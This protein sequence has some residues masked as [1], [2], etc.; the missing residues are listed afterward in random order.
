MDATT[1]SGGD[2]HALFTCTVWSDEPLKSFQWKKEDANIV[3]VADKVSA[4]TLLTM[5][6]TLCT[7]CA[8]FYDI[9]QVKCL[10]NLVKLPFLKQF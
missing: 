8:L 3:A 9:C 6:Y 1:Y 7:E 10:L 5:D 4:D 2:G